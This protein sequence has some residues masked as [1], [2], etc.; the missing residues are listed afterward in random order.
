MDRQCTKMVCNG[1]AGPL[2]SCFSLFVCLRSHL[3]NAKPS[4]VM[5]SRKMHGSCMLYLLPHL[6]TAELANVSCQTSSMVCCHSALCARAA[7]EISCK[8]MQLRCILSGQSTALLITRYKMGLAVTLN[9]GIYATPTNV[10]LADTFKAFNFYNK[11]IRHRKRSL[12]IR[13]AARHKRAAPA[14]AATVEAP[15]GL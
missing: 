2:L 9:I 1:T 10:T 15:P 3:L 11:C 14:A 12:P 5:L 13:E 8:I 6:Q 7:D 4:G